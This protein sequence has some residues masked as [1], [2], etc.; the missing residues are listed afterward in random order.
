VRSPAIEIVNATD[1]EGAD[2]RPTGTAFERYECYR[3]GRFSFGD[4][5]AWL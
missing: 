4:G 5:V 3:T 1:P 2:G